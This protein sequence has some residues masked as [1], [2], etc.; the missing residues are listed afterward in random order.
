MSSKS[1][2]N[3]FNQTDFISAKT[4]VF[5]SL[6]LALLTQTIAQI[7]TPSFWLNYQMLAFIMS[8]NLAARQGL[9]SCFAAKGTLSTHRPHLHPESFSH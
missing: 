1:E 8:T 2:W 6:G 9:G 4:M 3:D 5:L 7:I